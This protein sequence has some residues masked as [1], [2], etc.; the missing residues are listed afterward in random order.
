[1]I[2]EKERNDDKTQIQIIL[3]VMPS[4]EYQLRKCLYFLAMCLIK[5]SK[6]GIWVRW[7]G[8]GGMLSVSSNKAMI[9][10]IIS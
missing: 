5:S 2:S 6:W 8:V 7:N 4:L 9:T 3:F 10:L 1:M